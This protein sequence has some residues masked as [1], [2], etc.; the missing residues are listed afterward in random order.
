MDT[1]RFNKDQSDDI[2]Q[3]IQEG[4]LVAIMTD[5]VYGLAASSADGALYQKLKDAK[6]RPENKPFPLMVGSLDQIECVAELTD[7]DRHLMKTF[8]PGAVT[9]IFNIKDGVFPFLGDQRT[10]GIRMADDVWV[11][12]IIN[13]VGYPIWLPSANR[14]GFDTAISSDMVIDQLDGRIEGVVLGECVGGVS[15][16]VFDITGDEIK[17]LRQGVITLEEINKEVGL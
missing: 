15:S 9:F 13:K 4:G 14:S 1:K 10:I 8:M 12:D 17:C 16:S 5:T 3:M 7:R 11:Q 6:E 2:A